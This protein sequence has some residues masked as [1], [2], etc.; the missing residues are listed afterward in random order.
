MPAPQCRRHG[1]QPAHAIAED[2]QRSAGALHRGGK[3]AVKAFAVTAEI[4]PALGSARGAPVDDQGSQAAFRKMTQKA[5]LR[6]QVQDV[7]AVDQR[8]HDHDSGARPAAAM[9]EEPGGPF[10]PKDRRGGRRAA[11]GMAAVGFEPAQIG[12]GAQDDFVVERA[13]DPVRPERVDFAGEGVQPFP[14]R[15]Q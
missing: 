8:R 4:E 2:R 15:A 9:V 3:A 13:G 11:I 14:Y 1:E 7:V 5:A 10:L 12:F 6:Q